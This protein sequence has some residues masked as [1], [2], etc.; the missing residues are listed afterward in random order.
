MENKIEN[1]ITRDDFMKFFRDTDKLNLLTPDD[2]IEV[3]STIL[4]GSSDF[5]KKLFDDIFSDYCVTHLEVIE[6]KC[7]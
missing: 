2:R 7:D 6:V 1:E 5:K 4:L 3:F